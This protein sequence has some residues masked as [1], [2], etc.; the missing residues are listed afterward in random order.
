MT[1][2]SFSVEGQK[3]FATPGDCFKIINNIE[4]SMLPRSF[5][6]ATI[7]AQFNGSR[8]FSTQEEKEH[9]IQVNANFLE[10][11]RIAQNGILQMNSALLFKDRLFNARLIKGKATKR[12]EWSE[13]LTN[14]IHLPLQR[15]RSGKKFNYV[16][17]NR[18]AA[19]TLHGVGPL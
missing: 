9:Q 5:D 10:G 2:E 12:Q 7:N 13:K 8:P 15:G 1:E 18:N 14:N 16:M 11:Y 3:R 4:Y 6:R 19:L 17:Q